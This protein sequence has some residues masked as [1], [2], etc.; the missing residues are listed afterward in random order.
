MLTAPAAAIAAPLIRAFWRTPV[1][2][3]AVIAAAPAVYAAARG[4][5][6]LSFAVAVASIAGASCLGFAVDDPAEASL[7]PCPVPRAARRWIRAVLISVV[8][9]LSWLVV[10]LSARAA[11]FSLDPLRTRLAEAAAAAAIAL[12]FAARA[13]RDG[14]D[15]PGLAGVAATVMAIS[16][17]SGLSVYLTWLPQFGHPL[18]T[19]RWC[20]VALAAG[21]AGWWW[22]RDPAAR[23]MRFSFGKLSEG[24]L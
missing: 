19:T 4:Y 5:D 24:S 1:L 3:V 10:L 7:N 13:A 9:A 15:S 16:V 14:S 22:S 6:D 2:G 18:H 21:S 12:A 23:R 8:V 20:V 17:S 11:D